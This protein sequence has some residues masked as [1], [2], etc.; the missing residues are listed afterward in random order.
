LEH[1]VPTIG[2]A[3]AW[4]PVACA[5]CGLRSTKTSS[6]CRMTFQKHEETGKREETG[7]NAGETSS[8]KGETFLKLSGRVKT[9]ERK[10]ERWEERMK[11][12]SKGDRYVKTLSK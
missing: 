7:G 6:G 1:L 3:K 11:T 5:T 9:E 10:K 12:R 8:R 2:G 4:L